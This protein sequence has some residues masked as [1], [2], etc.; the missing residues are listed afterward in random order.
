VAQP[1]QIFFAADDGKRIA[2]DR[3]CDREFDRIRADVYCR[4]LQLPAT[5]R[6]L[7]Y[8]KVNHN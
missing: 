3:I 4:E 7:C 1:D 5:L 8:G 6:K 2:I